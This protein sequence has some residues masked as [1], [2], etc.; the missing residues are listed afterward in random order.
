MFATRAAVSRSS[1]SRW[2]RVA[3]ATS[4]VDAGGYGWVQVF[5]KASVNSIASMAV[6]GAVSSSATAGSIDK[7]TSGTTHRPITG[8]HVGAVDGTTSEVFLNWAVLGA[9]FSA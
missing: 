8:L 5:G 1:P 9:A 6:G 2:K 3:V 7:L 4:D